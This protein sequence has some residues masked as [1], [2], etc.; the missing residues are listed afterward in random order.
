MKRAK[1]KRMWEAGK[2]VQVDICA[3]EEVGFVATIDRVS[4]WLT[5]AEAQDMVATLTRA[6]I[7][8]AAKSDDKADLSPLALT[9]ALQAI[10]RSPN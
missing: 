2:S 10:L 7:R 8:S 3:E 5:K 4:I 1:G 9:A 6:L